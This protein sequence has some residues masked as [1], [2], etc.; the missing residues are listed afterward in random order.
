MSPLPNSSPGETAATPQPS[1]SA[2]GE[3]S[4]QER[5]L[6]LH[7]AHQAID[8]ALEDCEL[9]LPLISEHLRQQRG[10]FT[11]LHLEGEVRGCVGYVF[12][13]SPLFQTIIETARAA[14]FQDMRFLP[15]TREEADRLQ[16]SI[17]ILSL[18]FPIKA[19]EV[20]LGKHGLL[21]TQ[22]NHRGLL[23]PQ[24][25]AEHGWDLNTFLE[26]TCRKAG[27][28]PDAWQHQATLEAFTAEIFG[29]GVL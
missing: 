25:P 11:T 17:S 3:Y 12:P 27:L 29:E 28:R 26:Q 18:L 6:L 14:A 10:A 16:I 7:L 15:V 2:A 9:A 4:S 22:G 21:I 23:L 13:V 19:E 1:S 24:V 5:E 8:T 20:E